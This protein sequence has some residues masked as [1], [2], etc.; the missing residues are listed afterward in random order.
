VAEEVVT[1][2]PGYLPHFSLGTRHTEFADLLGIPFEVTQGGAETMYPEFKLKLKQM[3][4][5]SSR[6]SAAAAGK[7]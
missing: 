5:E 3:M 4:S 2:E 7:Q 6:S 1:W